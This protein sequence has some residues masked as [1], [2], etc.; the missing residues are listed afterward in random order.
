[1]AVVPPVERPPD[2]ELFEPLFC[3]EAAADDDEAAAA[4]EALEELA[5]AAVVEA[6][7]TE[8]TTTVMGA[9]EVSPAAVGVWVTTDVMRA[10]ESGRDEADTTDV[11]TCVEEGSTVTVLCDRTCDETE[12]ATADE[13]DDWAAD[14][15][16]RADEMDDC[17]LA[18][19]EVNKA[20]EDMAVSLLVARGGCEVA[21]FVF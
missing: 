14:E 6:E 12:E 7:Y 11:T 10:V 20:A 4:D 8:V 21:R 15:D 19:E 9:R 3:K 13:N 2:F 1:M 18:E 17:T 5:A 16:A